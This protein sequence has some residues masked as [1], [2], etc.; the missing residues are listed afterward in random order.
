MLL[1]LQQ[2]TSALL[3]GWSGVAQGPASALI[4]ILLFTQKWSIVLQETSQNPPE[5]RY[6]QGGWEGDLK[7][8]CME[9][10]LQLKK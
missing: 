7:P 6:P 8:Y 1:L 2:R 3:H 5:N 9:M 4:N 10:L